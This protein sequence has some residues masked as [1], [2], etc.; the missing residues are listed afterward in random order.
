LLVVIPLLAIAV[1]QMHVP[2]ERFGYFR[3]AATALVCLTVIQ[4]GYGISLLTKQKSSNAELASRIENLKDRIIVTDLWWMPAD[5][6]RTW[7]EHDYFLVSRMDL[8][9]EIGNRLEWHLGER[10]PAVVEQVKLSNDSVK[11]A[12]L[13]TKVGLRQYRMQQLDRALAPLEDAVRWN[14]KDPDA[15]YRLGSLKLQMW[16]EEGAREAFE[17]AVKIDSTHQQALKALRRLRNVH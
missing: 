14:D 12:A 6:A 16:D 8:P 2:T 1:S 7:D 3:I 10:P 15:W 9:I 17:Q 4:Q 13:A 5:M 11:W